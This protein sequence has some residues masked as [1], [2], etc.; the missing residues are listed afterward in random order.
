MRIL[1]VE[2]DRLP[3]EIVALPTWLAIPAGALF[4]SRVICPYEPQ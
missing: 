1:V 3:R 2:D 4:P